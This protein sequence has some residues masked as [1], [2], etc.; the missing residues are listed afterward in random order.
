VALSEQKKYPECER[1][2]KEQL[3][4]RREVYGRLD[5]TTMNDMSSLAKFL[6]EEEKFEEAGELWK[7]ELE[8]RREVHVDRH[9]DTLDA[10]HF[11]GR[12]LY[13]QGTMNRP[14]NC[15]WRRWKDG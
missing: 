8:C 7:E 3:A 11:Y 2:R 13:E 9:I 4:R 10:P 15:G 12:V 5:E 6:L 1:V 14:K